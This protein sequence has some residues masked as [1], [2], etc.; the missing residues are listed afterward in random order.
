[1]QKRLRVGLTTI[2][3]FSLFAMGC[4]GPVPAPELRPDT[5]PG[6]GFTYLRP[7]GWRGAGQVEVGGNAGTIEL[8]SGTAYLKIGAD[9]ADSLMADM[10]TASNSQL[11]G[12]ADALP[13]QLGAAVRANTKPAVEKLHDAQAVSLG[14]KLDPFNGGKMQ[15]LQSKLGEGR[16]SEY[17]GKDGG[18]EMHGYRVTIL[19]GDK[20]YSLRAQCAETDWNALKPVYEK[21]IQSIGPGPQN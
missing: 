12:V 4:N 1:M 18:R 13:G 8:T 20:R 5:G 16:F 6:N 15:L 9:L 21:I 11:G 7:K 19:G 10:M 17:T 3:C 14:K 2:C